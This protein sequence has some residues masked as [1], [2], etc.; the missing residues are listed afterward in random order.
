MTNTCKV[1]ELLP[2]VDADCSFVNAFEV[3][4]TEGAL[5]AVGLEGGRMSEQSDKQ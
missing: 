1:L 5:P 3:T 2:S 4:Q